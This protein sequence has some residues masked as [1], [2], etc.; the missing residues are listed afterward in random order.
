M[1]LTFGGRCHN[2]HQLLPKV[3]C[4]FSLLSVGGV[5]TTPAR[6]TLNQCLGSV[7]TV[8]WG[9]FRARVKSKET[10][11]NSWTVL[12]VILGHKYHHNHYMRSIS[13]DYSQNPQ[14]KVGCCVCFCF[15]FCFSHIFL[16]LIV[17]SSRRML[18]F[19]V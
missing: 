13:T 2:A 11:G 12:K 7:R 14:Q 15:C 19:D 3:C 9:L 1:L 16:S 18:P 5:H 8:L 6:S 4:L 10:V 17:S